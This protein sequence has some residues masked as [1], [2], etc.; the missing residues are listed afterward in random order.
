[1]EQGKPLLAF[2]G[3][4]LTQDGSILVA[5]SSV[6]VGPPLAIEAALARYSADG[7]RDPT[8]GMGGFA[9]GLP[10]TDRLQ[11]NSDLAIQADGRILVTGGYN[12]SLTDTDSAVGYV[13][14]YC[15]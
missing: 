10:V 3:L 12:D 2:T 13:A 4:E 11:G 5:G 9:S 14:R 6:K 15:P 7:V 8:F 1:V